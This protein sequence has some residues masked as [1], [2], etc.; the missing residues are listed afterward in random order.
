MGW[1]FVGGVLVPEVT[2]PWVRVAWQGALSDLEYLGAWQY[3]IAGVAFYVRPNS[4]RGWWLR[5]RYSAFDTRLSDAVAL[6][7]A[8]FRAEY[9]TLDY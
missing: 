8:G 9:S 2:E 4:V 6:Q 7:L 3:R 5:E 1:I